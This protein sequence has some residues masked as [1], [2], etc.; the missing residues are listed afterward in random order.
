MCHDRIL[1]ASRPRAKKTRR[2]ALDR[3]VGPA[4]FRQ[5]LSVV[6]SLQG[7]RRFQGGGYA[8]P[9]AKMAHRG[10]GFEQVA[11]HGLVRAKQPKRQPGK[12]FG[13]RSRL[14]NSLA[15]DLHLNGMQQLTAIL[16]KYGAQ[17]A[18]GIAVASRGGLAGKPGAC[19]FTT[20]QKVSSKAMR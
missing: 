14:V 18:V 12:E 5:T 7:R 13:P 1:D 10:L 3:L 20:R 16:C 8:A 11:E 9:Y 19:S 6:P 15:R 17:M 2:R 4:C